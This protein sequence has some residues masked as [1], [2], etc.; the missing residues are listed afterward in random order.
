[1]LDREARDRVTVNNQHDGA[2]EWIGTGKNAH[3]TGPVQNAFEPFDRTIVDI[4]HHL[5]R[6]IFNR[7]EIGAPPR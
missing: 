5:L 3:I 2:F 1:M 4:E 6:S 7:C